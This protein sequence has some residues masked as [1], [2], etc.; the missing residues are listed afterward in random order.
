MTIFLN[1]YASPNIVKVIKSRRMRWAGHA[2]LSQPVSALNE[3]QHEAAEAR[4][5]SHPPDVGRQIGIY[6]KQLYQNKT[7]RLP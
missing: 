3:E 5:L 1:V 7:Q 4:L 2:A 6:I